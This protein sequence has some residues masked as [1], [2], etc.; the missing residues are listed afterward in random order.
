MDSQ[1]S[2]PTSPLTLPKGITCRL[3][4]RN[5][6]YCGKIFIPKYKEEEGY[7]VQGSHEPLISEVLFYDVQDIVDGRKRKL[8]APKIVATEQ[9]PLRGFLK[10]P[11]LECGRMLTG[12]ASKGRSRYY[13]YYHCSSSC[14]C[15]FHADVV[16][17]AFLAELRKYMPKKQF[18]P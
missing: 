10:C 15:R 13:H 9:L 12:S 6:V 2:S 1:S 16:N 17:S 3:A 7:F 5:P 18:V 8:F 14:G 4:I 11:N